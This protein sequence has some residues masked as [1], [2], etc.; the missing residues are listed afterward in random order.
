MSSRKIFPAC[1]DLFA[2]KNNNS[3][4][5]EKGGGYLDSVW[6]SF[7]LPVIILFQLNILRTIDRISPNFVYALG[8]L[9]SAEKRIGIYV[10]QYGKPVMRYV[11]QYTFYLYLSLL[12]LLVKV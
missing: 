1:N 4:S 12:M 3:P 10:L 7:P 2:C 11:L 9:Q 8:V 5:L 6:P